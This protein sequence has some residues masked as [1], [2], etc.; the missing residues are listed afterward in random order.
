MVSYDYQTNYHVHPD[1]FGDVQSMSEAGAYYV[2]IN[3]TASGSWMMSATFGYQLDGDMNN[4]MSEG[5][6]QTDLTVAGSIPQLPNTTWNYATSGR[7]RTYDLPPDGVF[8]EPISVATNSDPNG[9]LVEF[10][11]PTF[12]MN[13]NIVSN[14]STNVNI[15]LGVCNPFIINVYVDNTLVPATLVPLLGAAAHITIASPD[16]AAYHA[17][18]IYL[19]EDET[20]AETLMDAQTIMAESPEQM[21]SEMMTDDEVNVTM[22]AMMMLGLEMNMSLNCQ[23]NMGTVMMQMGMTDMNEYF[24]PATFGP[25]LIGDF[26][27]IQDSR[28]WRVWP[29][30]KIMLPNGTEKLLVPNFDV[31]VAPTPYATSGMLSSSAASVTISFA[32]MLILAILS[33]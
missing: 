18:A 16:Q 9:P 33:L 14:R 21:M 30:M 4:P 11:I 27:W 26:D 5:F 13:G 28:S 8:D 6:A 12:D 24:G 17:H 32:A 2:T 22:N 31:Y 20:W 25:T 29:W 23:V 19:V 1:D 15:T 10:L 3:F 7:F